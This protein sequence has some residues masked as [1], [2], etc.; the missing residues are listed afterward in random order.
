LRHFAQVIEGALIWLKK[1]PAELLCIS[2]FL[3]QT[4][5]NLPNMKSPKVQKPSNKIA[6][7]E[8]ERNQK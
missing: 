3:M 4:L 1:L 5:V 7:A 2:W 6:H 8:A